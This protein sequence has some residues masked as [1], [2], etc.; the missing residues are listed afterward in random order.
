MSADDFRGPA[1]K[2]RQ[3]RLI[4]G[5]EVSAKSSEEHLILIRF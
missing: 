2:T 3:D 5:R 1:T 4:Q